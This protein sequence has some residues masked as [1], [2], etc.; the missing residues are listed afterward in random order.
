MNGRVVHVGS[1]AVLDLGPEEAA[2]IPAGFERPF[3]WR[4]ADL[5][6]PGWTYRLDEEALGEVRAVAAGASQDA[7]RLG[8]A[9]DEIG[10]RLRRGT[11][12]AVVDRLPVAETGEEGALRVYAR[13]G[14][15]LGRIVPTRFDG[16]LYYRV[17]D[18]GRSFGPGVRGSST[19]G[20]LS[21]HTDN[22]FSV[23]MP[24]LVGLLCLR[25]AKVGGV[26]FICNL[27]RIHDEMLRA[28]R[29][30]LSRL[31]RPVLFDR[32]REHSEGAP[33]LLRAPLFEFR[34]GMLRARLV[35][36]LIRRGYE[37]AGS[38]PDPELLAALA[39]LDELL[40]NPASSIELRLEPGQVLFLANHGIAHARTPYVDG[41]EPRL[42]IRTWYR[43]E[44]G[45]GY[46]G[47]DV[48]P[49]QS[50]WSSGGRVLERPGS[51][52]TI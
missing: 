34:D 49:S 15:M 6:E 5:G 9:M 44:G 14:Q 11:G 20:P 51:S 27:Y 19:N 3:G 37:M 18:E 22:A 52:A 12:F 1:V 45:P 31:Y 35:P 10:R 30:L 46:D 41:R 23:L 2:M 13:L 38:P 26:N 33:M 7:P 21:F 17:T 28:D 36:N 16:T 42:L 4:P 24:E 29:S 8:R 48:E 39:L 25:A 47:E 32:Q 50:R 40:V 43:D